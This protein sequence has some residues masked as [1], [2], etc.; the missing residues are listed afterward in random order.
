MVFLRALRNRIKAFCVTGPPEPLH[1]IHHGTKTMCIIL[2]PSHHSSDRQT[3]H[4]VASHASR[5]CAIDRERVIPLNALLQIAGSLVKGAWIVK[6]HQRPKPSEMRRNQ[7]LGAVL[8]IRA[9]ASI[10][11]WIRREGID[12]LG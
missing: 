6:S 11:V 4:D 5:R 7:K 8:T 3:A 2:V 9:K 12:D 10:G 1:L